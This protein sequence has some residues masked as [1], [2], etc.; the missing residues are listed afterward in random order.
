MNQELEF[1]DTLR[2]HPTHN[3]RLEM[4]KAAAKGIE[5]TIA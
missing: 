2:R 4:E 5:S 3:Y 1:D